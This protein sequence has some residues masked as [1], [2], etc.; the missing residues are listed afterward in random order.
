MNRKIEIVIHSNFPIKHFVVNASRL[1]DE[2][3]KLIDQIINT[4][5]NSTLTKTTDSLLFETTVQ[6]F[7]P[8]YNQ[9]I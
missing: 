3:I 2:F 5:K 6:I 7:T 1:P 4:Y 8:P 9:P